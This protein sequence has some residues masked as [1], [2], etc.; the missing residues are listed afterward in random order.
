MGRIIEPPRQIRMVARFEQV[1]DGGIGL[2]LS[3]KVGLGRVFQFLARAGFAGLGGAEAGQSGGTKFHDIGR[4]DPKTKLL[5]QGLVLADQAGMLDEKM[6][7][8]T[9]VGVTV[10]VALGGRLIAH[11]L[12]VPKGSTGRSW[13]SRH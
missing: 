2:G 8:L 1:A 3:G 12:T 9:P 7:Y 6:P 10:H 5:Q 11:G 13:P 4:I